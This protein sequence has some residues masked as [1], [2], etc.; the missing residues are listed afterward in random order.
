MKRIWITAFIVLFFLHCGKG[1]TR[2]RKLKSGL[3]EVRVEGGCATHGSSNDRMQWVLDE[4]YYVC[5]DPIVRTWENGNTSC[6]EA[7]ALFA[8]PEGSEL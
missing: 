3:Y 2:V 8:C 5:S 7:K 1:E 4:I 6:S